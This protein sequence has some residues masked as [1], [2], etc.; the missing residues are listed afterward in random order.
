MR[1]YIK[2]IGSYTKEIDSYNKKLIGNYKMEKIEPRV[3]ELKDRCD[4]DLN[5]LR[6]NT[7]RPISSSSSC[8]SSG[9]CS[10]ISSSSSSSFKH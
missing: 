5:V 4:V 9:S 1:E 3:F 10:S 6:L 7:S 2:K 8:S